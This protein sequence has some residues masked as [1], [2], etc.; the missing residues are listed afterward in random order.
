MINEWKSIV[1]FNDCEGIIKTLNTE[2]SLSATIFTTNAT[3][4]A[5]GLNLGLHIE[6]LAIRHR[7]DL[8]FSA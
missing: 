3:W 2:V 4:T 5:L 1:G 8:L 7:N 6:K